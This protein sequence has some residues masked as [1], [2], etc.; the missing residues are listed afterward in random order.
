MKK[1]L[2]VA[3]EAL[4]FA[5]S[6]GLGDVMGALPAAVKAQEPDADVRVVMPLYSA[7]S[8]TYRANMKKECEF[9]VNVSWRCQYGDFTAT[10]LTT[11]PTIL[12]IMN[13]IL[14]EAL[15]TEASTT[16]KDL[17]ISVPL[18]P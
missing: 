11:S 12:L 1:I 9:S 10:C 4:P 5:S 17:H 8:D 14:K 13:I 16:V 15:F 3:S 6:G 7:I 18:F 2:Y